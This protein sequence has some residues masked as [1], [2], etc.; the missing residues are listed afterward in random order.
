MKLQKRMTA[1][2]L[3]IGLTLCALAAQAASS[4]IA[5]GGKVKEIA[6]DKSYIVIDASGKKY[7][8]QEVKLM[9]GKK[10]RFYNYATATKDALEDGQPVKVYGKVT[11]DMSKIE[12]VRQICVLSRPSTYSNKKSRV[13]GVLV[14]ENGAVKAVKNKDKVLELQPRAKLS[15]QVITKVS[16]DDLKKGD[17][18]RTSGNLQDGVLTKVSEVRTYKKSQ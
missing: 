11:E 15:V 12:S 2:A 13:D 18:I 8:G 16:I 14:M 10:T 9:V 3:T 5:M 17:K 7:Q 4:R 1:I 6:Q